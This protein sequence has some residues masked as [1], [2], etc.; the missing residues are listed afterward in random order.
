MKKNFKTKFLASYIAALC[1][2]VSQPASA[3]AAYPILVFKWKTHQFIESI[4]MTSKFKPGTSLSSAKLKSLT[5]EGCFDNVGIVGFSINGASGKE[6]GSSASKTYKSYNKMVMA[7][8]EVDENGE[9]IYQVKYTCSGSYSAQLKGKSNYFT[10]DL[11]KKFPD[12]KSKKWITVASSPRYT[13]EELAANN[14]QVTYDLV[15]GYCG[16]MF[17]PEEFDVTWIPTGTVAPEVG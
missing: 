2:I 7:K 11:Y 12:P 15:S 5:S 13:Y 17:C 1:L 16:P 3:N 9:D 8:W 4:D 10:L 6:F 14:W